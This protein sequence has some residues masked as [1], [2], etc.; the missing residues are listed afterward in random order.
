MRPPAGKKFHWHVDYLVEETAVT[1]SHV[2]LFRSPA[3]LEELLGRW[4]GAQ[5]E[6][7]IVV[8]GLGARDVRGST[9]LL[10]VQA[11]EAWWDTLPQRFGD[12]R[13]ETGD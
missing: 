13:L 4:L 6:T 5:P 3:R 1:L 2:L 9:H 8:P 7:F 11:P 12:E 10:G